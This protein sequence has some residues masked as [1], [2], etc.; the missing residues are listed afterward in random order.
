MIEVF[1]WTKIV[2]ST[3]S[4]NGV[5]AFMTYFTKEHHIDWLREIPNDNRPNLN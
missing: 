5:Y 1:K 2:E 3:K 4:E